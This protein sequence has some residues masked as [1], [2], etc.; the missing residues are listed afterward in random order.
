[1]GRSESGFIPALMTSTHAVTSSNRRTLLVNGVRT[2]RR[3]GTRR[4]L[5]FGNCF[6]IGPGCGDA[7]TLL[8]LPDDQPLLVAGSAVKGERSKSAG[9]EAPLRAEPATKS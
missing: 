4:W 2:P 5:I 3:K 9:R 6:W 7:T 8:G 1:M